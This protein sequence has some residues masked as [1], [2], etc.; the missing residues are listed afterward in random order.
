MWTDLV[1]MIDKLN[2]TPSGT[3]KAEAERV[4]NIDRALW[5]LALHNLLI[6][7]D[8]Y[9]GAGHNYYMYFDPTDGRMNMLPW[10]M[11]EAFGVRLPANFN[12][13]LKA[14]SIIDF[15]ARWHNAHNRVLSVFE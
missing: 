9:M 15:W 4:I 1:N 14:S 5:N 12:S 11:N 3:F 2:N 8:D 6:N 7:S 10:D 13:P